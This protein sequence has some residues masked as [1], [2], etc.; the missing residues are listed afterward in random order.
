MQIVAS[1]TKRGMEQ[2][3]EDLEETLI[4]VGPAAT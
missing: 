3:V 4:P 2:R 1:V